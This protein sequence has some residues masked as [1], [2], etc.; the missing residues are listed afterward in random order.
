[1][2]LDTIF[3]RLGENEVIELRALTQERGEGSAAKQLYFTDPLK[4]EALAETMS[5]KYD[6]YFGACSRTKGTGRPFRAFALWADIDNCK[7]AEA[8]LAT[9]SVFP[10]SPTF[11]VASGHGTHMY[12]MLD[13]PSTDL[14][15]VKAALAAVTGVIGADPACAEVARILRIP[16]TLNHKTTPGIPVQLFTTDLSNI[17]SLSD[18]VAACKITT[19]IQ[20]LITTG[21]A[22]G[23]RSRSER[24]WLVIGQLIRSGMSDDGIITVFLQNKV[25]AKVNDRGGQQYLRH[26]IKKMREQAQDEEDAD[27]WGVSEKDGCYIVNGGIVSTFVFQP[28]MLLEA[29]EQDVIYGDIQASGYVWQDVALP[30][31]AFT[32]VSSLLRVLPRAAWQWLGGDK[33][34]RLLLPHLMDI[35][36][37]RG[38]PKK[39]GVQQLGRHDDVWVTVDS[40]IRAHDVIPREEADIIYLPTPRETPEMLCK[41]CPKQDVSDVLGRFFDLVPLINTPDVVW[42]MIGWF[43]ATPLKPALFQCGV[44]FPILNVTGT[45]GS[46]KTSMVHLLL[47][48]VGYK[49]PTSYDCNTTPFVLL[50]LLGSTTSIPISLAE[51]RAHTMRDPGKILRYVLLSYDM[52]RDMRGRS[53]QSTLEYPLTAPMIVDGEEPITDPAA[54]ERLVVVVTHPE[55]ILEGTDAHEV[56]RQVEDL[57][58]RALTLSLIQHSLEIDVS[59]LHEEAI[60]ICDVALPE[61][62]PTRVRSNIVVVATGLLNAAAFYERE[63]GVEFP[64]TVDA[65]LIRKVF[66]SSEGALSNVLDLV[67]GRTRLIVDDFVEDCLVAAACAI[68]ENTPHPF[69]FKAEGKDLI[70]IHISSAVSWWFEKRRF[71]GLPVMDKTVLKNQMREREGPGHGQYVLGSKTATFGGSSWHVTGVDLPRARAFGLDVPEKLSEPITIHIAQ[72]REKAAA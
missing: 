1:M 21:S 6:V 11:T 57:D 72:A 31:D 24:D 52:S 16:G 30:K 14:E 22:K 59:R 62:I 44:K 71:R 56:F 69:V 20:E 54:K 7:P 55:T 15:R 19:K 60:A 29:P 45:R 42:P 48:V 13:E 49:R 40:L 43:F 25:G 67:S 12:W 28:K 58:L 10:F 41:V 37:A 4:T 18:L 9:R 26:S 33:E 27:P 8:L 2:L 70:W 47:K 68:G 5:E 46:G 50:S 34:V 23:Y 51:Y 36:R 66:V 53:D 64:I 32:Q 35:I 39:T 17:Y 65:G 3:A 61:Q 38:L 63:T